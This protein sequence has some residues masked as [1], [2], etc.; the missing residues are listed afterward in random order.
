MPMILKERPIFLS[1]S[2][3]VLQYYSTNCDSAPVI[4]VYIVKETAKNLSYLDWRS[5]KNYSKSFLM[6]M[7]I[8]E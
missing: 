6:E 8:T 3:P 1:L 2:N 5:G 7:I 4:D